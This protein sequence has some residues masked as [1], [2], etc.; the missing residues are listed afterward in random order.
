MR[1]LA[2][3]MGDRRGGVEACLL[4][5][6]LGAIERGWEAHAA[7]PPTPALDPFAQDLRDAGIIT[8]ALDI[9]E[10]D[11]QR[12]AW[13]H[14]GATLELL[15]RV[16]PDR[17]H[18]HINW[19]VFGLPVLM[20]GAAWGVPTLATYHLWREGRRATPSQR[21]VAARLAGSCVR[22]SAVSRHLAGL[23]GEGMGLTDVAVVPNGV[24]PVARDWDELQR[25]RAGARAGVRAELGIA[26]D[27][28]ILLSLGRLDDQKDHMRIVEALPSV[29]AEHPSAR[30][31]WLGE[32]DLR[33]PLEHR[34]GA[35][36]VRDRV[37]FA[38]FRPDATRFLLAADALVLPS[39]Y[40]G[41]ALSLLEAIAAGT[42]V[43]A[44]DASSNPEVLDPPRRGLC[45]PVGDAPAL[46]EAM[47]SVLTQPGAAG[48]RARAAFDH[49][50]RMSLKACVERTLDLIERTPS[51]NA[52]EP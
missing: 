21:A 1:Y 30:W 11:A 8:H 2:V 13:E 4:H 10:S 47:R 28:P 46:A 50:Q 39:K 22:F 20:A 25:L 37:V 12:L 3:T 41:L 43:I 52:R 7:F 9:R 26:A 44:S 42:P 34:L 40:E 51:P 29:A 16:R 23:L 27:A 31:V 14:A 18:V 49:S 48:V 32:G 17:V 24:A 33:A 19:A 45:V 6:A 35:L 38:G 36:G 15:E 5:A